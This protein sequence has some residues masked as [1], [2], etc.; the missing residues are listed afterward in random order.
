MDQKLTAA[1]L[2]QLKALINDKDNSLLVQELLNSVY[3]QKQEI[4]AEYSPGE[5]FTELWEKISRQPETAPAP[6]IASSFNRK[7]WKYAAAAAIVIAAGLGVYQFAGRSGSQP[8]AEQSS[9]PA[10]G[11]SDIQPGGNKAILTLADGSIVALTDAQNGILANQGGVNV[12]KLA[13][14]ELS[15]QTGNKQSNE[16]LFNTIVT[17]RGGKYR[18]TLPDGSKVWLNAESS[19]KYPTAFAGTTREVVLRGEAYFEVAPNPAQPFLVE[20]KETKVE[21]LGTHFNIMAYENEGVTAT[22]LVE[23]AVRVSTMS[24]QLLLKPG[25]QALHQDMGNMKLINDADIQQVVAWKNDYF[26]FNAERIDR[27]M[28]QLE[29]WYDISVKY[30]GAVPDRKFGGKI[31][32][33]SPLSDVLRVLELSNVKFRTEGKT[34]TVINK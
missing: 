18:L 13:N 17:P 33:Q 23:G 5:A 12:V 2:R 25:Q 19:L 26:Q 11:A 21:V 6:V 29:R 10:S 32:R 28:R 7:W 4:S 34:I 3:E 16:I 9:A 14:G 22:T 1:E 20:V 27:L 24:Q 30:E 8:L 15:Y 31:S